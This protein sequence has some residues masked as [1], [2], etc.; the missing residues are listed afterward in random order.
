MITK[1][2]LERFVRARNKSDFGTNFQFISDAHACGF[3][4]K[5]LGRPF[6][7]KVNGFQGYEWETSCGRLRE[8]CGALFLEGSKAWND[9][10]S[11]RVSAKVC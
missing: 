7:I 5:E 1:Q 8:V 11:N 2:Q 6:V 9:L 10:H 3:D 4:A